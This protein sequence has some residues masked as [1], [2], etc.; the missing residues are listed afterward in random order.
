[1][2]P[3]KVTRLMQ[4]KSNAVESLKIL[5]EPEV[6]ADSVSIYAPNAE[7]IAGESLFYSVYIG[8]E[9]SA[10]LLTVCRA[11]F[12]RLIDQANANLKTLEQ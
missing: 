11:H 10:K 7:H 3:D 5:M 4:R 12:K 9:L 1:M 2:R 8:P 6:K